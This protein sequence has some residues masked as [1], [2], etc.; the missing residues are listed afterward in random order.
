MQ[1]V[2]KSP[3]ASN[4]QQAPAS[5]ALQSLKNP[6]K[7][8]GALNVRERKSAEREEKRGRV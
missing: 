4:S 5:R 7:N 3:S 6:E 1:N 8:G 2:T